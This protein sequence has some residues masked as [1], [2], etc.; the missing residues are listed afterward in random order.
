MPG[1]AQAPARHTSPS[2]QQTLPPS[3]HRIP[4]AQAGTQEPPKHSS[5]TSQ[6]TAGVPQRSSDSQRSVPPDPA[7]PAIP[8]PAAA[9]PSPPCPVE[10]APPAPVPPVPPVASVEP[11]HAAAAITKMARRTPLTIIPEYYNKWAIRPNTGEGYA[12][13]ASMRPPSRLE[14]P[15][16][17]TGPPL[18]FR[19]PTAVAR[20]LSSLLWG[21]SAAST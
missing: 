12:I 8:P 1:V 14:C 5:P 4:E 3:P 15:K 9:P 20:V 18:L 19:S 16:S 6:Q 17:S 10:P 11:P 13:M 7:D 21:V 2:A